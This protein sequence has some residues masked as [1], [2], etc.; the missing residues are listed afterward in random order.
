[1]KHKN[2]YRL[3]ETIQSKGCEL[4]L[5]TDEIKIKDG[6]VFNN[7]YEYKCLKCGYIGSI[8]T[9]KQIFECFKFYIKFF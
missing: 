2:K 4:T 3:N 7:G 9:R 5:L 1:M 6:K 8:L